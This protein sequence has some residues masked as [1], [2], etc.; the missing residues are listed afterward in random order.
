MI[1][2]GIGELAKAKEFFKRALTANPHFH[3]LFADHA[4]KTVKEIEAA[5]ADV[6]A[7]P[8]QEG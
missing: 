2:H 1:Y 5:E 8:P 4:A 3:I 6:A 7:I